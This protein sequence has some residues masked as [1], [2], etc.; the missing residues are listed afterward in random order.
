LWYSI[1]SYLNFTISFPLTKK[2]Q[3]VKQEEEENNQYGKDPWGKTVTTTKRIEVAMAV[4]NKGGI[5]LGT[6]NS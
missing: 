4:F 2:C 6:K 3:E 1:F 5:L